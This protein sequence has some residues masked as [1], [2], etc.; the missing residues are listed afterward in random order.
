MSYLRI[1]KSPNGGSSAVAGP[2]A[3]DLTQNNIF[4]SSKYAN[5]ISPYREARQEVGYVKANPYG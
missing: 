3:P 2:T 1:N 4:S 5:K